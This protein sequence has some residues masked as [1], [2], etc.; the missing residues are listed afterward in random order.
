MKFALTAIRNSTDISPRSFWPHREIREAEMKLIWQ[1]IER[2]LKVNS[3]S[4]MHEIIKLKNF[5]KQHKELHFKDR[6]KYEEVRNK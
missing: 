5:V 1:E 2:T 4:L 3:F 6:L